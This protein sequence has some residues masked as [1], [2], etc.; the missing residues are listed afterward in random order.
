MFLCACILN[1]WRTRILKNDNFPLFL[2]FTIRVAACSVGELVGRRC[3]SIEMDCSALDERKESGNDSLFHLHQLSQA[4]STEIPMQINHGQLKIWR[5]YYL[6][7]QIPLTLYDDPMC[8]AYWC[9]GAPLAG[10]GSAFRKNEYGQQL[11]EDCG[12]RLNRCKGQLYKKLPGLICQECYN[13]ERSP[14]SS[15]LAAPPPAPVASRSHKRKFPFEGRSTTTISMTMPPT[16]NFY[17]F[18]QQGWK[19]LNSSRID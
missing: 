4:A 12:K 7:L 15:A 1:G 6:L 11:C 14:V 9:V 13:T 19:L 16:F 5:L 17:S 3:C 2:Q 8:C 18:Q 10:D